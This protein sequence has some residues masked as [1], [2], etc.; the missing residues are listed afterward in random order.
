VSCV[1]VVCEIWTVFCFGMVLQE[2][3]KRGDGWG[4]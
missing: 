2:K 1:V 3:G 4:L